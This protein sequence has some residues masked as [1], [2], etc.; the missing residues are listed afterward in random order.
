MSIEQ[1]LGYVFRGEAE[2]AAMTNVEG[3]ERLEGFSDLMA[4]YGK[5]QVDTELEISSSTDA[6]VK[7]A[8]GMVDIMGQGVLGVDKEVTKGF[9]VAYEVAAR[10]AA[11]AKARHAELNA[12][13]T[14][15]L[16][17]IEILKKYY[18]KK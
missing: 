10:R 8:Q 4:A 16:A 11:V 7:A 15:I 2:I 14:K 5:I 1:E 13:G 17:E 3:I 9:D 18:L 6:A 12:L